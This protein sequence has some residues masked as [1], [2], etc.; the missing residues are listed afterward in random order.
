MGRVSKRNL[1]ST[2]F[3]I[4]VEKVLADLETPG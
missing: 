2:E 4:K 3:H 1:V